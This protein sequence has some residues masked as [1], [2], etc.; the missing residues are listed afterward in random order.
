MASDKEERAL[1]QIRFRH[2]GR[3]FF[4]YTL[5][6]TLF[7]L[8]NFSDAFLILRAQSIGMET[9]YIPL[10]YLTY[11]LVSTFFS[12]PVG[13]LSDR[14]GR[15]PVIVT[16]YL[17][18]AFIYLGFGIVTE[19]SWIWVL[20]I[21]YGLYYAATEGI[22]RAYVADLVPEGQKGIAM[23]TFNAMTGFAALPASLL[24]GFLWQSFGPLAAFE[25]SSF[26]AILSALLMILFRI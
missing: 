1:P 16:G 10:A 5:V 2:L 26:L 13:M 18:F 6:S 17:I 15:R 11:N 4:V 7:T 20:F 24:A 14:I 25:V 8:S 22:Q 21:L 12:V 23:G 19:V 3:P 9:V